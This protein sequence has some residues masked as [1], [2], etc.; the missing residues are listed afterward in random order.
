MASSSPIERF[1]R[2]AALAAC[3]AA[4]I[5]AVPAIAQPLDPQAAALLDRWLRSSCLGDEAPAL[6]ADLRRN[7]AV[8]APALRRALADGPPAGDI[9]RVRETATQRHARRANFDWR[10]MEVTG[11]DRSAVASLQRKSARAVVDDQVKRYVNGWRANAIAGLA[12]VGEPVDRTTLR[13]IAGNASD[14]AALA[15][16]EALRNLT[17]R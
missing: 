14:P 3:L 1:S 16:R 10:G 17:V 8:L 4:L 15:A 7:A 13:R 11:V 6:E 12:I 2:N 5:A 9:A